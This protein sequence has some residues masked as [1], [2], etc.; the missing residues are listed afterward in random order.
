MACVWSSYI[1]AFASAFGLK[2]HINDSDVMTVL[3]FIFFVIF[4]VAM[5]INC[6]TEFYPDMESH[7]CRDLDKIVFRYLKDDFILDFVALL[8]LHWMFNLSNR[9]NFLFAIKIVR[10]KRANE[11]L[12]V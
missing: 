6:I 4:A 1:Y 9:Y 8:P 12:N 5:L 7:P 3:D 2:H 11:L 10:L